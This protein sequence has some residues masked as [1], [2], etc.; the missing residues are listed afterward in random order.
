M[1]LGTSYQLRSLEV[2]NSPSAL[3]DIQLADDRGDRWTYYWRYADQ[4]SRF[5]F[6]FASKGILKEIE[7]EKSYIDSDPNWY[8][9][10]DHRAL[11][12]SII[13]EDQ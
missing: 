2:V 11:I 7:T 3:T 1:R 13:A 9:A 6:V 5:D 4:Y 8:K 10:S 12:L